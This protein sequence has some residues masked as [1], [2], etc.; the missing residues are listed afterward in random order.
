MHTLHVFVGVIVIV[1]VCR[2]CKSEACNNGV[3]LISFCHY[4][5]A[6]NVEQFIFTHIQQLYSNTV[7]S[8]KMP[9]LNETG[10]FRQ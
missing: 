4:K 9:A 5:C 6:D 1:S 7:E 3:I 8:N 10:I 2:C